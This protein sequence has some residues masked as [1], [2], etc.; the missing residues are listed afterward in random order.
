[1]ADKNAI[2][3]GEEVDIKTT[4]SSGSG[5]T[6][7]LSK[8]EEGGTSEILTVLNISESLN[9]TTTYTITGT[10]N[11]CPEA[12]AN[13]T[14]VVN[15][16][17][18]SPTGTLKVSYLRSDAESGTFV[19]LITKDASA[20]DIDTDYEYRWYDE[21]LQQLSAVPVPPVPAEGVTDDVVYT[22][23]VDR[24][25]PEGCISDRSEVVVTIYSAP[26]PT[27]I[28]VEY[29]LDETATQLAAS[30]SV[31]QGTSESDYELVWYSDLTGSALASA[32]IPSTSTSGEV[33]YYVS[34]INK[35]TGAQSSR[36]PLAVTVYEV[37][38]PTIASSS[39]SYCKDETALPLSATISGVGDNLVWTL[40][41]EI[42]TPSSINTNVASTTIYDYSVYQTYT[43]INGNTCIGEANN[44]EVKVT[45]VSE[46]Q[47]SNSVSYVRIDAENNGDVFANNLIEQDNGVAIADADCQLIWYDSNKNLIGS[48]T[49]TPV[50]DPSWPTGE[51]VVMTYYV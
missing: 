6:F 9:V 30:I 45:F 32:P 10:S 23:Y 19:D 14:V 41:G 3:S 36:V 40:N 49:P 8:L 7:E 29:C 1:M 24:V 26:A 22:Y 51:D 25:S 21:S 31:P 48:V 50:F 5:H 4:L 47:G 15:E 35:N 42:V 2:C 44:V 34:Q 20:V 12:K 28:D 38:V 13:V 43:L 33:V 39:I 27:T 18:A 16:I 46:P 11:H 37:G 17:P